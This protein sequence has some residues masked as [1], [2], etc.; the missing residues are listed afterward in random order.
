MKSTAAYLPSI[1]SSEVGG[2]LSGT[3]SI[4]LTSPTVK[5]ANMS[6]DTSSNTGA[7]VGFSNAGAAGSGV[8]SAAWV[9]AASLGSSSTPSSASASVVAPSSLD[10]PFFD[11]LFLAKNL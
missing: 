5:A 4:L 6:L 1:V 7:A 10:D 8:G 3:E 2:L 9:T 11:F